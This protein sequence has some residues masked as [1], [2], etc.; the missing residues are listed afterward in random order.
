MSAVPKPLLSE[1]DY[2]CRERAADFKSE[3]HR[4]EMFAMSGATRPHILIV[5]N[6]VA[7]LKQHLRDS[8]CE[9]YSNDMRVKVT[10]TGLYTYPDVVVAC[11]KPQFIDGEFDTL[12]NPKVLIEVLS[13]STE[14]YDRGDKARMYRQIPSLQEYVIVSQSQPLV[15]S[16]LRQDGEK[17]L[18]RAAA[19]IESDLALDSLGIR[20]PLSEIY[21]QVQ[22]PPVSLRQE[23]PR[24]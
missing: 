20:I 4:G 13:E 10:A 19:A 12:L 23:Y 6:L 11:G 14:A 9:V 2:L 7:H 5:G 15:E 17:W 3:F 21:R 22:F 18:F 16:Y 24:R 8:D 1:Q